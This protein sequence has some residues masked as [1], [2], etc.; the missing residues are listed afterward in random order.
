MSD[1]GTFDARLWYLQR[2]SA[3]LLAIC[4]AIHLALIIYVSRHGMSAAELL[5]RTRRNV[6]FAVFYAT[7]VIACA[8]HVPIGLRA[9]AGEWLRWRGRSASVAALLVAVA[10]LVMG[11][12]SVY[13]VSV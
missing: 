11:L 12:R 8:I 13:A 3:M 9:I 2:M 1:G 10:I 7:F 6:P 5:V 4:V